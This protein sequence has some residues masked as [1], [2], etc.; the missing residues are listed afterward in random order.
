[1]SVIKIVPIDDNYEYNN[2]ITDFPGE[3]SFTIPEKIGKEH[4]AQIY[5]EGITL[6][7]NDIKYNII[8]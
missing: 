8:Y 4:I 3:L 2:C 1:M 7:R 5:S 6:C